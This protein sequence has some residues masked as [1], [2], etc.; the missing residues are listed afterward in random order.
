M[1]IGEAA[2]GFISG[3]LG[4]KQNPSGSELYDRQ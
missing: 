4:D 2:D 1:L 3:V